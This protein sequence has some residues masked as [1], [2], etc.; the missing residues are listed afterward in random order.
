MRE[1]TVQNGFVVVPSVSDGKAAI[2]QNS[3]SSQNSRI[4]KIVERSM[5]SKMR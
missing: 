5:L 3:Q 2:S 1:M 4:T